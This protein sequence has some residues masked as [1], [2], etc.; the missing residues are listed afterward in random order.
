MVSYAPHC[1]FR[2]LWTQKWK[3]A[4]GC[5]TIKLWAEVFIVP[6]QRRNYLYPGPPWG[7]G[8]EERRGGWRRRSRR[9]C[10]DGQNGRMDSKVWADFG[11]ATWGS[12]WQVAKSASCTASLKPKDLRIKLGHAWNHGAMSGFWMLNVGRLYCLCSKAIVVKLVLLWFRLP[13]LY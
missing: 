6:V 4:A 5:L 9:G 11:T 13:T 12:G 10:V 7:P 3:K 1:H 2:Q 8:D